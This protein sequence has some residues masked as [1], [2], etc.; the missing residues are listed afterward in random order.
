MHTKK[1]TRISIYVTSILIILF[2]FSTI[3]FVVIN[4]SSAMLKSNTVK[5]FKTN[6]IVLEQVATTFSKNKYRFMTIDEKM[7]KSEGKVYVDDTMGFNPIEIDTETME[8]IKTLIVDLNFKTITKSKN[9]IYFTRYA[10]MGIG[11]GLVYSSDGS[12]PNNDLLIS[13]EIITNNWY[14]Y[15]MS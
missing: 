2:L 6:Q 8:N 1:I 5:S 4:G 9:A 11:Y 13:I 7:L 10:K 12:T 15:E 14:Y 3:L